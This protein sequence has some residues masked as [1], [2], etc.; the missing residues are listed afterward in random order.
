MTP[1]R[2]AELLASVARKRAEAMIVWP[3]SVKD[4]AELQEQ[5]EFHGVC[6]T[7]WVTDEEARAM[8]PDQLGVVK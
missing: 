4:A 2:R 5:M 3:P 1:E 8:Y 7:F 6:L